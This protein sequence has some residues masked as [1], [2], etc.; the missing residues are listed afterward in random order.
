MA[1]VNPKSFG[2]IIEAGYAAGLETVAVY[3]LPDENISDEELKGL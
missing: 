2:T 3:V 1:L